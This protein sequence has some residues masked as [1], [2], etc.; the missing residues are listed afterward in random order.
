MELSCTLGAGR[1]ICFSEALIAD[2]KTFLRKVVKKTI[3]SFAFDGCP[4]KAVVSNNNIGCFYS[5]TQV[6]SQL[7]FVTKVGC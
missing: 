5:C 3:L 2:L 4:G 1:K 7:S 6:T